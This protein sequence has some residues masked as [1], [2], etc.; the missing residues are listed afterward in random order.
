QKSYKLGKRPDFY[1]KRTTYGGTIPWVGS[2][3]IDWILFFSGADFECVTA[4]HDASDNFEHGE[5][6]IVA[7]CLFRMKNGIIADA[8]IDYLRP[9]SA[10]THGDDRIRIAG[11]QGVIEVI[12]GRL[13]LIDANGSRELQVLPPE[14]ELFSDYVT[15]LLTSRH[16]LVDDADTIKLARAVLLARE[17][18]DTCKTICF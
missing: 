1:R 5:L 2:H 4:F 17:S 12:N 8:G 16:A 9:A 13:L 7:H 10:A 18:A 6:E 15:E 3:A 11:T 14:R